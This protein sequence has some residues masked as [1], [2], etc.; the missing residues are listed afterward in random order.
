MK[1]VLQNFKNGEILVE[2]V[3]APICPEKGILVRNDFSLISAG[4][5]RGTVK[6]GQASMVGK[7]KQRPDLVKQVL[8]NVRREGLKSTLTKVN[9]RLETLKAL[10]YSTAGVVIESRTERFM[11]G[12]RVACAG[13]D[14][15]SHAEFI[16]VP[17]NLA[18]QIPESVAS[19]DA[20]YTTV[21]AIAMQGIRQADLRV[22][23]NVVV[24]GMGLLGLLTIQLAK[25]CGC[26]V[27]ALDVHDRHFNLAKD[28]GCDACLLTQ[29]IVGNEI[30]H[31][32]AGLGADAVIIAASTSSNEPVEMAL[33]FCRKKGRIVILGAVNMNIPR[34]PFYEKEIDFKI[35]CSYGPG[36]YDQAYEQKGQDYPAAYVR[37]TEQRNMLAFLDLLSQQ[38]INVRKL[39]S[40]TFAVEEAKKAYK[41]VTG[42]A[43]EASLGILFRY[44]Q[45]VEYSPMII[46]SEQKQKRKDSIQLGVI[47]AGNFAKAHLLPHLKTGQVS[48]VAIADLDGSNAKS[49]A[50]KYGVSKVYTDAGMLLADSDIDTVVIASRHDTH[51]SFTLNALNHKKNVY[52]EKPLVLT[53]GDLK[54]LG[55]ASVESILQ[56]G[57]NRRFS[58]MAI[59]VKQYFSERVYPLTINIRINAGFLAPDYWLNDPEWGGGRLRGEVCHFIDL[60][61]YFL[62]STPDSVYTVAT[63]E[64]YDIDRPHENFILT[65]EYTD[66]ST[67]CIQ[68]YSN[69]S[70][71]LSKELIEVF[72]GDKTATIHDFKNLVFYDRATRK[73]RVSAGKGHKQEIEHF[74]DSCLGKVE[75]AFTKQDLMEVSSTTLA[76]YESLQTGNKIHMKS[77]QNA[78][79]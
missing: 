63:Q 27:I 32:T 24:I 10:G 50:R 11:V 34:S 78:L 45:D 79:F 22:G 54:L 2:K 71:Q 46:S 61:Q 64:K 5:E 18:A 33:D 49:V 8:E 67:A 31:F 72:G 43:K 47:G 7:A 20:A 62:S 15:A 9:S 13:Q 17:V 36:R 60:A 28:F 40:H 58:P 3:P 41:L 26:R 29:H 75:P 38:K 12:D 44:A 53:L 59:A 1:Q 68:Y 55:K 51:A 66:G 23:E 74:L 52:V 70:K 39:T 19:E 48:F 77:F 4:T 16:A 69:G 56:V 21:G 30:D 37:W 73:Q 35:S 65:I 14:I 6:T 76:A 42:E 25:A 57:F